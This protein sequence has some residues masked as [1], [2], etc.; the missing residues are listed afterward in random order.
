MKGRLVILLSAIVL[1]LAG[2][3]AVLT[4]MDASHGPALVFKRYVRSDMPRGEFAELVLTNMTRDFELRNV[5]AAWGQFFPAY[6]YR[7]KAAHVWS[8]TRVENAPAPTGALA[9]LWAVT[10]RLTIS[11]GGIVIVRIPMTPG[12]LPQMVGIEYFAGSQYQGK[13]P[14]VRKCADLVNRVRRLMRMSTDWRRCTVWCPQYLSWPT[15]EQTATNSGVSSV[16][17]LLQPR[18]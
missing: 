13:N 8:I 6:F 1:L 18:S 10:P 4:A 5:S 16:S 2:A 9:P 17:G 14:L 15:S 11:A 3:F 12:A 7:R